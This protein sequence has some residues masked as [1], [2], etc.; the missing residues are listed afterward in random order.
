MQHFV[1]KDAEMEARDSIPMLK[2]GNSVV[3]L[4]ELGVFALGKAARGILLHMHQ[5]LM[6][7]VQTKGCIHLSGPW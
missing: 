4:L 3:D 2:S 6:E 1:Q 5:H 7:G